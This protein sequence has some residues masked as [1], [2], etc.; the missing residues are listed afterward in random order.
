MLELDS[1]H[2]LNMFYRYGSQDLMIL[3]AIL[4]YNHYQIPDVVSGTMIDIGAHIGAA[5]VLC[6]SRG[7]RV[8][9]YEPTTE[10]FSILNKNIDEN[11][12]SIKAFKKAVGLPG[13]RKIYMDP[14]NTGSNGEYLVVGNPT[15]IENEVPFEE[16]EW[17][18]LQNI[19]Q[20]NNIEH[21][22]ILKLDCEGSEADV[23]PQIASLHERIDTIVGEIHTGMWATGTPELNQK[24]TNGV[25]ALS[26]FYTKESLSLHEFIWTHK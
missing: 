4:L 2:G 6:S 13:V 14:A 22:S 10:S 20:D 5:S 17:V 19:F 3:K 9:A 15:L 8:F 12:L 16:V 21:C 1:F 24:I 7:A 11:N 18:S 23:L 25:D 26:E